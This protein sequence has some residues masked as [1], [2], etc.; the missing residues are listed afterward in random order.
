MTKTCETCGHTTMGFRCQDCGGY[1]GEWSVDDHGEEVW[2]GCAEC[3]GH[4]TVD[5]CTA[6]VCAS[7]LSS[8]VLTCGE[9]RFVEAA[10]AKDG[11]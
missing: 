3:S 5:R 2:Q 4:G 1:G 11:G 9:A 6:L 10:V 8:P 7:R